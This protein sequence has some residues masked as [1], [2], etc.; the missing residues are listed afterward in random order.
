MS[1]LIADSAAVSTPNRLRQCLSKFLDNI[2]AFSPRPVTTPIPFP[3]TSSAFRDAYVNT[4]TPVL[5][6]S[7]PLGTSGCHWDDL[8][9]VGKLEEVLGDSPVTVNV[10]PSHGYGDY[11]VTT[12]MGKVSFAPPVLRSFHPCP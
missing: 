10:T 8:G 12:P 2:Y 1:Q 7:P 4:S 6:S 11:V 3:P 5:F 9:D